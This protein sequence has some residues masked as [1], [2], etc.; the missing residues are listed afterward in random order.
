MGKPNHASILIGVRD[1]FRPNE[2]KFT[3]RDGDDD[4][5]DDDDEDDDEEEDCDGRTGRERKR[6]DR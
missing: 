3:Q 4:D 1:Q 2:V 6:R 5:S